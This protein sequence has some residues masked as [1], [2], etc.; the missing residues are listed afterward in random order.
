MNKRESGVYK[1]RTGNGLSIYTILVK[2]EAN[3]RTRSD[4]WIVW[5]RGK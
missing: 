4:E 3:D 5:L 1:S 2:Q